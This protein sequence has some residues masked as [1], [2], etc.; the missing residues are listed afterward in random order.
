M[1]RWFDL[2]RFIAVR[3]QVFLFFIT[4]IFVILLMSFP[5]KGINPME[6]SVHPKPITMETVQRWGHEPI[7]VQTGLTVTDFIKFENIK[8]SFVIDA[9]VWFE[10]N[11][12]KISLDHIGLF[13]FESARIMTKSRPVVEKKE[14]NI[15]ARYYVRIKFEGYLN[16]ERFPVDDHC[17]QLDLYN[18][19][20]RADEA[21]FIIN[22]EDFNISPKINISGW[23]IKKH[24]VKTGYEDVAVINK[25]VIEHPQ[26]IF[27]IVIDK[28]NIKQ[29]ILIL[30]PLLSIFFFCMFSLS[31]T[32][33]SAI[34]MVLV[35]ISALLAYMFVINGMSPA[36]GALMLSDYFVIL[37]LCEIFCIFL[38]HMLCI[39]NANQVTETKINN[40]KGLM[41]IVLYIVLYSMLA[42]LILVKSN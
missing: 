9:I 38:V 40:I 24:Y 11:P 32:S 37:F 4:I 31:L 21:A 18:S 23:K 16:H 5:Y 12:Q 29:L 19:A 3:E 22:P 8:N 1:T 14:H 15:I 41:V 42:Y 20:L 10:F 17:L 33:S 27:Y 30:L 35:S 7:K 26:A 25:E 13:G 2:S 34:S 39:V 28:K 36:S 6:K